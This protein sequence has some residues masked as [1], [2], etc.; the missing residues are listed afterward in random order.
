VLFPLA[1]IM[2]LASL[3]ICLITIASF[4]LFA[5][6]QTSAASTHQQRAISGEVISPAS[7]SATT[8]STTA[9]SEHKSSLRSAVDDASN[10]ITSPFSGVVTG[11]HSEWTLRAIRLLLALAVYGF[12]L[13]FLAR[14]VKVRV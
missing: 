12:G 10:A 4:A 13:G 8:G 2:H 7:P 9:A 3:V 1:R 5:I 6:N 11:S 14:F